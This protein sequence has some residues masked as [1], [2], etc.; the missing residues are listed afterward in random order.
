MARA[1]FFPCA[2]GTTRYSKENMGIGVYDAEEGRFLKSPVRTI[3]R[4]SLRWVSEQEHL[5]SGLKSQK[6]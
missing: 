2:D 5:K 4:S 1:F 6:K 3:I